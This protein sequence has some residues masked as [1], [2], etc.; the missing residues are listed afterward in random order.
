MQFDRKKFFD[1]VRR[2]LESKDLELTQD[3]VEALEFLITSFENQPVWKNIAHISYALATLAHETAWTFK[4]IKE[5]RARVGSK[6]R[7]NQDRYWLS[8]YYGRGYVQL[9]WKKNYEKFGLAKAPEL[10]LEPLTAFNVL[11]RGMH[12]GIFTGKKLSDYISD[13]GKDYKNAR[14]IINGLDQADKIA[15]YARDFESILRNS[16]TNSA[17]PAVDQPTSGI[18]PTDDHPTSSAIEPPTT[19]GNQ[20]VKVEITPEGGVKASTN[21]PTPDPNAQKERIAVVK[22]TPQK[23]SSRVTAKITAAV[24]GSALFQWLWAQ[25]EKIQGL[26]VPDAVWVI[27]SVTIA[28]GSLLWILHEIVDTWRENR[29]QERVDELLVKENSTS[30]NLVQ[31]IPADE[32]DLYRARGFKIITRGEKA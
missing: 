10:A 21:E 15:G 11:T 16:K 20:N 17:A 23:W 8:G 2:F 29:N 28:V 6:G 13:T 12:E 18:P 32:V 7:A 5:Y 9:T 25:M 24:T 31:L 1:G 30:D 14:K 3:R 4:P 22:T 27:V 19:N 26:S